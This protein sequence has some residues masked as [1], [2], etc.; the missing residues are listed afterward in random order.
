MKKIVFILI[1]IIVFL[2]ISKWIMVGIDNMSFNKLED[3]ILD[4]TMVRDVR[5]INYY[6][7]Y[8]IVMDSDNLYLFNDQYEFIISIKGIL[9]YENKNKYD[10]VY[11]DET[12]MYMNDYKNKDEIIYEYY[13]IYS[14]ELIDKIVVGGKYE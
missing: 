8:Y 10:I 12:I 9:M 3:A 2:F 5:Y 7:G 13:D 4:N 1:G 14:Y 11:R 6:D